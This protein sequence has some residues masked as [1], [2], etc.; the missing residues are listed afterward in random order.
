MKAA[1]R[2]KYGLSEQIK[3][4]VVDP[5]SP[6]AHEVLVQVHATTVNR[7]DCA[8]AMG[9]PWIMKLFY[10]LFRPKE[11]RLGTDFAGTIAAVG[12]QVKR[13]KV[14]DK[15]FG[16]NDTGFNSQAEY[17]TIAE[18]GNIALIP[19]K[20]SYQE[21]VT[22]LEGAHYAINIINKV[23]L[24]AGQK[25]MLNGATGAIGSALLQLLKY[26]QLEVCAVCN[27]QNIDLIRSLGADKIIDY[28]QQDFTQDPELYDYVFDAVGKSTFG[29]SKRLLLPGGI[30]ISTELGPGAQNL[31][32]PLTT[33]WSSKKVIFPLP[34]DTMASIRLVSELAEQGKFRAVIDRTYPF[35]QV[36]AAYDYVASGQKTGNVV[37]EIK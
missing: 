15:V 25:V 34:L 31:L 21:A 12:A 1:I 29:A 18:G 26:H 7:T 5:P 4:E 10:G 11:I 23:E 27:T 37:L 2:R 33:R 36:G 19:S 30:Y 20:A 32:L 35:E 28:T 6:K 24:K 16:L 17:L 3:I 22:F 9:K 8:I 14:G 13:F